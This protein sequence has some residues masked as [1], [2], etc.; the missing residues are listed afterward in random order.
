[1]QR[2]RFALALDQLTADDGVIFEQLASAFIAPYYGNLRTVAGNSGDGGRDAILHSPDGNIHI[3]FQFSVT[4]Y[5]ETKIKKTAEALASDNPRGKS[6]DLRYQPNGR[7]Q[8][9]QDQGEA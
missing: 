3:V 7:D 4:K 6:A 9:R 8:C 2:N 5:P 1:M